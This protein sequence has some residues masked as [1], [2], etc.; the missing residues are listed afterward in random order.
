MD[1]TEKNDIRKLYDS[2][3][4]DVT[5]GKDAES[6]IEATHEQKTALFRKWKQDDQGM[7]WREFAA[8]VVPFD[9]G[10]IGVQWCGMWLGIERDGYT[11]S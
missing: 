8:S 6:P 9:F 11:H 3:Y 5:I 4:P 2:C 7:T 10:A 1:Y